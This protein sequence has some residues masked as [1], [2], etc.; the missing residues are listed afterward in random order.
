MIFAS[1]FRRLS[2]YHSPDVI[3]MRVCADDGLQFKAVLVDGGDDVIRSFARIDAN[4]AFR[5]RAADDARVLL[6]SSDSDFF[7]DH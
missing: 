3:Q 2:A 4:R 5:L 7:D 1:G 6:E